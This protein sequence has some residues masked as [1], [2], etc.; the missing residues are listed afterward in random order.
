MLN[1]V[2]IFT[3]YNRFAKTEQCI[4]RLLSQKTNYEIKYDYYICDDDSTD[5]TVEMIK[6]YLPNANIYIGT[7]NLF[8]CKGMHLAMLNATKTKHDFY[9]MLNDDLV[10]NENMIQTMLDSYYKHNQLCAVAGS[11]LSLDGTKITYG[12]LRYTKY[13]NF[14]PAELIIPSSE[15][16][17][18]DIA[19]W[20]CFLIPQD[21][22]DKIGIIDGHYEHALGDYDYCLMM[23]KRGIPLFIAND[24]IGRTDV[25]SEKNTSEDKTLSKTVRIKKLFSRKEKP[26]K[27]Q[28]HFYI[29]NY[30]VIGVLFFI[31]TYRKM[32]QSII[33]D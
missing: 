7:S 29:K 17:K 12:G 3:C 30:G 10:P 19:N 26:I 16:L 15:N 13:S 2:M 5:G 22:I 8:W 14:G 4:K 28:W 1:I 33:F 11:T 24:F 6:S 20:N 25:N 9:L 31:N 27:S 18:C 21:V 23:K 32:L